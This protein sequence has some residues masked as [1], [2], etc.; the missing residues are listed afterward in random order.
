MLTGKYCGNTNKEGFLADGGY[1]SR[2][3]KDKVKLH[4]GES[5]LDKRG[6]VYKGQRFGRAWLARGNT[7]RV[8]EGHC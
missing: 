8:I 4:E 2:G 6:S 3:L 1:L 7:A 5:V